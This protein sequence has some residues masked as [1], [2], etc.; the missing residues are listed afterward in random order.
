MDSG[1]VVRPSMRPVRQCN[2]SK[3]LGAGMFTL[4]MILVVAWVVTRWIGAGSCGPERGRSP[5]V[6]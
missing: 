6:Y 4:M 2:D 5:V 3:R 1:G